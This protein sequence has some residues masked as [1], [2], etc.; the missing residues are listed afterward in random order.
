MKSLYVASICALLG[1]VPALAQVCPAIPSGSYTCTNAQNKKAIQTSYVVDA[2]KDGKPAIHL[3]MGG[4]F[5]SGPLTCFN[6]N[7]SAGVCTTQQKA[8]DPELAEACREKLGPAA[9][10]ASIR[11]KS[12]ANEFEAYQNMKAQVAGR[13]EMHLQEKL[14]AIKRTGPKTFNLTLKLADDKG[15]VIIESNCK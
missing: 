8:A 13:G 5:L 2:D 14:V 4:E 15:S 6:G 7:K 12:N 1:A 10:V 9:I 11:A 3:A